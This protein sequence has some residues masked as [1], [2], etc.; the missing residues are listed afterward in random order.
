MSNW[1]KYPF[2]F[3]ELLLTDKVLDVLGFGEYWA[4]SGDFGERSFGIEFVELYRIV[5]MDEMYDPACGYSDTPEYCSEHFAEPFKSA[6]SL[7]PIYF[8]HELYE[9]IAR[10]TPSLLEMFVNKTKEHGV[11]MYPQLQSYL[12][13]KE[14]THTPEEINSWD[15]AM[16]N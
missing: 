11:N 9:S 3:N 5:V 4:G 14:P 8:L 15:I 2:G 10:N 13:Y 1:M 16:D 7:T 12:K 6:T